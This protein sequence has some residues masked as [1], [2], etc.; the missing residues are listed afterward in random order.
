MSL[1]RIEHLDSFRIHRKC[2]YCDEIFT[3][4]FN[5]VTHEELCGIGCHACNTTGKFDGDTNTND[6]CPVCDGAGSFKRLKTPTAK[7]CPSCN[8]T[9]GYDGLP[10][11]FGYP[12]FV[13]CTKCNG[14][15]KMAP[16][17]HQ[18]TARDNR[19]E[20]DILGTRILDLEK[21]DEE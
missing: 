2:R 12:R 16:T 4:V 1:M 9:G 15:G 8:G 13:T 11:L 17:D 7:S 3:H 10:G 21:Q 18:E 6:P 19:T 5:L 20:D 14:T